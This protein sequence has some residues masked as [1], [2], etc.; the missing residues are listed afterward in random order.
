VIH[1]SDMLAIPDPDTAVMDRFFKEPTVSVIA[2]IIDPI[3]R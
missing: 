3:T 2:D 1:L